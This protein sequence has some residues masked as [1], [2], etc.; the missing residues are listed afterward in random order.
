[1]A[2]FMFTRASV[3]AASPS[4]A[5]PITTLKRTNAFRRPVR[6]SEHPAVH[7]KRPSRPTIQ[8]QPSGPTHG[9]FRKFSHVPEP[10]YHGDVNAYSYISDRGSGPYAHSRI[11]RERA[12]SGRT[13][14]S[15]GEINQ[16][17][18]AKSGRAP[19]LGRFHF[20][21]GDGKPVRH[22]SHFA[23]KLMKVAD[24]I[25]YGPLLEEDE[26]EV[27]QPMWRSVGKAYGGWRDGQGRLFGEG[28]MRMPGELI[29]EDD[30]RFDIR[31]QFFGRGKIRE[32]GW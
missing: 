24:A 30:G 29:D 13:M 15:T 2:P 31:G 12:E 23:R 6:H 11:M 21:G 10:S 32:P 3:S 19:T 27:E 1:M 18:N 5:I 8:I 9:P 14:F 16:L 17:I 22:A 20:E 7:K 28:D 26:M 25:E 4:A